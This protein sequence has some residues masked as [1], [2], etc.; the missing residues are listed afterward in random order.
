MAVT[1]SD[2]NT[3]QENINGNLALNM[4]KTPVKF[5]RFLRRLTAIFLRRQKHA[6]PNT[7][8][9]SNTY[10][11]CSELP[12]ARFIKI[13]CEGDINYLKVDPSRS[14][15]ADLEEVWAGIFQEYLELSGDDDYKQMVNLAA[16]INSLQFRIYA[17][18]RAL[19][20]LRT[21][22]SEVLISALKELGYKVKDSDDVETYLDSLDRIATQAA[23]L[24]VELKR[25][26]VQLDK[27]KVE[28]KGVKPTEDYFLRLIIDLQRWLGFYIDAEK[29][30]VQY[31]I[32]SCAKMRRE[33]ELQTLK[34]G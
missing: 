1:R 20:E 6:G 11:R 13:V 7:G 10:I 8:N 4:P 21:R 17:I 33:M 5:R 19:D 27:L 30:S 14:T 2:N 12:L 23:S 9:S 26:Q 24:V 31:F 18:H 29:V 3:S 25:K 34:H 22:K 16:G 15:S 28:S 32:V